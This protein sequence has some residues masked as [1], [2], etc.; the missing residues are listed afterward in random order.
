LNVKTVG[1]FA[2]TLPSVFSL[3]W[4]SVPPIY[5]ALSLPIPAH[6]R[7]SNINASNTAM[8]KIFF[9]EPSFLCL[10]STNRLIFTF[11]GND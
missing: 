11:S 7:V 6:A 4:L 5:I 8:D 1:A 3:I 10:G 2:E 9:T